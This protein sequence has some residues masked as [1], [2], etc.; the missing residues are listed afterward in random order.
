[1]TEAYEKG[2]AKEAG[3]GDMM[4]SGALNPSPKAMLVF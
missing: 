2:L 4:E 1:M 3:V